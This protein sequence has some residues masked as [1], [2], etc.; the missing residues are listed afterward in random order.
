MP[1]E[2]QRVKSDLIYRSVAELAAGIQSGE[3]SPVDLVAASLDRISQ[4]DGDLNAFLEVWDDTA[5]ENALEA[6]KAISSGGYLGPLHGIPIGLKDLIDVAGK[7]TTGGSKVLA[8]NVAGTDATVV[9][10]L[11]SAGAIL[12]GKL[13]LVDLAGYTKC[14]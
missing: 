5:R 10:K 8:N 3:L 12:V 4:L 14:K 7:K 13:N 1:G 6:E 9:Q 2:D 11:R